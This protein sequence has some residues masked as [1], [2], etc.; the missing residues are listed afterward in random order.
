VPYPV[1]KSTLDAMLYSPKEAA[2][3]KTVE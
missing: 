2:E 3:A 1:F